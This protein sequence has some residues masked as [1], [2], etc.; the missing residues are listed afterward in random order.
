L[1]CIFASSPWF[2]GLPGLHAPRCEKLV[3]HCANS[4]HIKSDFQL[5]DNIKINVWLS[6]TR[7]CFQSWTLLDES[8]VLV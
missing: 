8:N 4:Q 2:P 3:Y 6:L 7:N 1:Q 5:V